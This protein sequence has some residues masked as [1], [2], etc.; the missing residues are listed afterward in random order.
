MS[1]KKNKTE[2][3][4]A[5][6]DNETWLSLFRPKLEALPEEHPVYDDVEYLLTM[7]WYLLE[8]VAEHLEEAF[9]E[10]LD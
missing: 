3:T 10:Y 1:E 2:V 4:S 8:R 5:I 6:K 7:T 9:R